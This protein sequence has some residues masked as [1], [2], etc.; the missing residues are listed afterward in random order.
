M[1]EAS[2][3]M[4][5]S[6]H[7]Y[8]VFYGFRCLVPYCDL[9]LTSPTYNEKFVNY[10]IPVDPSTGV[11]SQCSRF[12][13]LDNN[14]STCKPDDFSHQQIECPE[15]KVFDETIYKSTVVSEVCV[16]HVYSTSTYIYFF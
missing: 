10:T 16:S 13:R 6:A 11:M 7:T 3:I 9:N 1:H 14:S 4:L 15:G 12:K 5:T 8:T 2:I